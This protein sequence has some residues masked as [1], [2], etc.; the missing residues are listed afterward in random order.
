MESR[1]PEME[2]ER[3]AGGWSV[4]AVRNLAIEVVS[5]SW[6]AARASGVVAPPWR[7]CQM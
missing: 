3:S 5:R 7:R 4:E 1:S 6:Y 2:S